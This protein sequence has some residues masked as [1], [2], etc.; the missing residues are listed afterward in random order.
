M[1]RLVTLVCYVPV[2]DLE[3]FLLC[4]LWV[5]GSLFATHGTHDEAI[6]VL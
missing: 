2:G 6:H 5:L 1:H 4:K 3:Q